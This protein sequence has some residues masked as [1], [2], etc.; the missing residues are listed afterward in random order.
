MKPRLDLFCF[1]ILTLACASAPRPEPVTR[2]PTT[3]NASF[4]KT[5]DAVIDL[6]ADRNIPIRTMDRASGFISA[7][8]ALAGS[9]ED[10]WA[11]CG[12]FGMYG[13][14]SSAVYNLLVRGDSTKSTVRMTVKWIHASRAPIDKTRECSTTGVL[15]GL[16]ESQV[17][18]RA[19]SK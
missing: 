18:T 2:V 9:D 16:I 1:A 19:E 4:N 13:G 15:E 8:P 3:V 7:E 12:G 5:W 11:K 17:R 6:F 10:A 14:P